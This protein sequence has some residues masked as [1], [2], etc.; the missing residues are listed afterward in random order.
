MGHGEE[1]ALLLGFVWA[2]WTAFLRV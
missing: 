1:G 2:V